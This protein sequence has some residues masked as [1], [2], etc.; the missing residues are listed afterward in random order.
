MTAA[1]STVGVVGLAVCL[2]AFCLWCP[3][4]TGRRR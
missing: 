1:L 4:W 2:P 3:F